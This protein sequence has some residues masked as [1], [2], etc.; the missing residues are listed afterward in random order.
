MF[1]IRKLSRILARK[2]FLFAYSSKI[3][4]ISTLSNTQRSD[5]ADISKNNRSPDYW[6]GHGEGLVSS[7]KLLDLS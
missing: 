4:Y 3:E 1:L 7:L 6:R 2:L 5:W